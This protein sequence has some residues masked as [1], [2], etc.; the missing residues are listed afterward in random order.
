M[1]EIEQATIH[2]SVTVMDMYFSKERPQYRDDESGKKNLQLITLTSLFISAKYCMKDSRGPTARDISKITKKR[3]SED[4]VIQAEI[5]IS[6]GID[7]NLMFNTAPDFLSLI[8]NQGYL[9]SDDKVR[10]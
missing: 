7:W 3:Y 8:Q 2:H 5:E 10:V 4:E 1:I 9:F 6:K